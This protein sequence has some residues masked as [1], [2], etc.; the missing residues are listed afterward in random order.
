MA[1]AAGLATWLAAEASGV[2]AWPV[3]AIGLSG[4]VAVGIALLWPPAL[5]AGLALP[6]AAYATL[7][8]VDQPSLDGRAAIVSA[9]LVVIAGLVDWSLELRASSPD[10]PGGR[11]RRLAWVAAGGI[12]ALALGGA[13]LALVDLARTEGIVVEAIGAAAALTAIV[14]VARLASTPR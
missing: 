5:A 13:L 9:C 14:L 1:L 11:W 10:E 7:L 3:L 6:G 12:G 8:A 4:S 2:I